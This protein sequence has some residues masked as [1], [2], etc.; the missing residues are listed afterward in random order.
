M[1]SKPKCRSCYQL[2]ELIF[3]G[4]RGDCVVYVCG[5]QVETVVLGQY[6]GRCVLL[7]HLLH[8]FSLLLVDN[9]SYAEFRSVFEESI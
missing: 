9:L 6:L 7:L 2:L 3:H 5:E 8:F 4:L 1:L